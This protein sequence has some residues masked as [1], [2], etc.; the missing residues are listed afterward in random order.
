MNVPL[1]NNHAVAWSALLLACIASSG[2]DTRNSIAAEES[3][4]PIRELLTKRCVGCHN[5]SDRKGG[6]DLS[7]RETALTG[8]DSG[9]A[10]EMTKP[11]RAS[12]G[13]EC[14]H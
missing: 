8:G 13:N 10:L 5:P 9:P 14:R 1:T 3:M 12:C 6:L 2:I 4:G 11:N 7:V